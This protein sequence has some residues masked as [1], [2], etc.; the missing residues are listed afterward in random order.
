M[1]YSNQ[2]SFYIYFDSRTFP[3][4]QTQSELPPEEPM[5]F[6]IQ[7]SRETAEYII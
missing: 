5:Y 3:T 1:H 2:W 7:T 4:A 6:V